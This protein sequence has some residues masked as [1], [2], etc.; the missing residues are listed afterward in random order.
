MTTTTMQQLKEALERMIDQHGLTLLVSTL[1]VICSEKA[2]HI[3]ENWQDRTT[4][5]VWDADG[6]TLDRAARAMKSDGG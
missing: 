4:A 2:D 3:R 5:K 6:H 1:G